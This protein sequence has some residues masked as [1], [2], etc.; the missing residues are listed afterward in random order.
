[1]GALQPLNIPHPAFYGLAK[2]RRDF[3]LTPEWATEARNIYLDST[4][5][6]AA[7][8]G[9][10]QQNSAQ[11]DSGA[12]VVQIH[13]YI[14]ASG[15]SE[16]IFSTPTKL[17]SGLASPTAKTGSL[18][19][20][21]GNWKF[22]NFNGKCLAWTAGE[23]PIV[24]TGSG[25]FATISVATGTLPNGNAACA[26]FGRV[27][28][29]DDDEQTIRY[30]AL[31]DETKWAVA[32]GG[33]TIDMRT[34]WTQGM[35]VVVAIAAFGSNLVVFGKRHVIIWADGSG[36]QIGL[37][38]L[39]MY[40]TDTIDNVGA[41]ARDAVVVIGEVDVLFWSASGIRSLVRT[42]QERASPV[43]DASPQNRN[44]IASGSS[45]PTAIRSAYS[46]T[47]G[48][49]LFSSPSYGRLFVFDVRQPLPD[50]GFR[51][52]EWEL[53]V[54]SLAATIAGDFYFGFAGNIGL[55]DG[56][57]DDDAPY[58]F[59]LETGWINITGESGRRQALKALKAFL[60]TQAQQSFNFRWSVDFRTNSSTTSLGVGQD[61][62]TAEWN[63]AAAEWGLAEW[64][65]AGAVYPIRVPL[66]R[67]AEYFK[68][69]VTTT[70]DG[71]AVAMQP[72][73]LYSK[74]MRLA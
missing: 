67:E 23:D 47:E 25:N 10:V 41:L 39:N 44:Y 31:L 51:L 57:D 71:S 68:L 34:V 19:F 53:D 65:P 54:E 16:M 45:T 38:P 48:L 50:G 8:K 62:T 12:N 32:D 9:W 1:M 13:E 40:V 43:N 24:Y 28:A 61:S 17:Y 22:V 14:N 36:S 52:T 55:Y 5:R 74:P 59:W 11:I 64:G 29:T 20:T 35:D 63:T 72:L 58:Q 60:F 56:Y 46:S 18:T 33:G 15:T 2:D 3:P 6:I 69:R 27:W 21:V 37:N 49:V 7:R 30:S 4:G 42:M 26:A 66:N 70:I 73:T